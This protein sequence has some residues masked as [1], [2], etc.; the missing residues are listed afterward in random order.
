MGPSGTATTFSAVPIYVAG[1]QGE[2]ELQPL[3]AATAKLR[4]AHHVACRMWIRFISS[5]RGYMRIYSPSRGR[6]LRGNGRRVQASPTTAAATPRCAGVDRDRGRHLNGLIARSGD[7]EGA[8]TPTFTGGFQGQGLDWL[9]EVT[10][11]ELILLWHLTAGFPASQEKPTA[12]PAMGP[13]GTAARHPQR[14]GYV[15]RG[16]LLPGRAKVAGRGHRE[17]EERPPCRR[18]LQSHHPFSSNRRRR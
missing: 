11:Q 18:V 9:Q 16:A 15:E 17:A 2:P 12:T 7:H 5:R 10:S 8:G 4:S 3:A 1:Q 14:N 13:S 6:A